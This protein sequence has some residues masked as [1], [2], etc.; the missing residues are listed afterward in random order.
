MINLVTASRSICS[1]L[2][3]SSKTPFALL[4]KSEVFTNSISSSFVYS[5]VIPLFSKIVLFVDSALFAIFSVSCSSSLFLLLK[6]FLLA[7]I[8]GFKISTFKKS[9]IL[10]CPIVCFDDLFFSGLEVHV[11]YS[12]VSIDSLS[13]TVGI[14]S[15]SDFLNSFIT[16]LTFSLLKYGKNNLTSL[17]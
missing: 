6:P 7:H 3:A 16:S 8:W 2:L 1:V 12:G 4:L 10:I 14:S 13:T 15:P 17:R 5:I 9:P 11:V